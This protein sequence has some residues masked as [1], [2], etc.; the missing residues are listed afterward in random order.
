MSR[1]KLA[2]VAA[3]ML[4]PF[5]GACAGSEPTP[6]DFTLV[7]QRPAKAEEAGNTLEAAETACK[8]ETKKKGIS[9][10]L[11]IFSRFRKG[12]ADE[13][14]VACMKARGYEVKQ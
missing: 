5:L 2:I 11:A 12:A 13:D 14:Y 6:R 10:V 8:A 4:G 7:N 1:V 3:S 9:N